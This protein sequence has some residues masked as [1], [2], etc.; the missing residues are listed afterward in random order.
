MLVMSMLTRQ[1]VKKHQAATGNNT[2]GKRVISEYGSEKS[3]IE[4]GN[5][6]IKWEYCAVVEQ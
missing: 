5:L 3:N 1:A 2:G 6:L 4:G